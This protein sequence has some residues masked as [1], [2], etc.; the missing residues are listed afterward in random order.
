LDD[1]L[2]PWQV[3]SKGVED[4][5]PAGRETVDRWTKTL[6]LRQLTVQAGFFSSSDSLWRAFLAFARLYDLDISGNS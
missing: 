5:Q 2:L 6:A 3:P 4:Q 1:S